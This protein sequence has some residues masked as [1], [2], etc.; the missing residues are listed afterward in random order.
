MFCP[1]ICDSF[2]PPSLIYFV[3]IHFVSDVLNFSPSRLSGEAFPSWGS[4][5]KS[6]K[7][8]TKVLGIYGT[9]WE[10]NINYGK[11]PCLMGKS[12]ISM[13]LIFIWGNY[14]DLTVLP[15]WKSWFILGKSSP[16]GRKIQVSEI[17]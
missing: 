4:M 8:G 16:N 6:N 11:S 7:L 17:L 3:V 12:T 14:T 5:E 1:N 2:Y 13:D 9:L 10:T 15:H